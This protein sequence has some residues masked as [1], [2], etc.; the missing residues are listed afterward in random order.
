[1]LET[2]N[3]D[4]FDEDKDLKDVLED[5]ELFKET[6]PYFYKR[7]METFEK[8]GDEPYFDRDSIYEGAIPE[9]ITMVDDEYVRSIDFKAII[10]GGIIEKSGWD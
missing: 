9:G 1:M 4:R 5:E 7:C 8:N 10:S 2:A 6:F 3:S